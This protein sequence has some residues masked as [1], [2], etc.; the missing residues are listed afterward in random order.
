[1]TN[2][3]VLTSSDLSPDGVRTNN[4]R[5]DFCV[6]VVFPVA[7]LK[8]NVASCPTVPLIIVELSAKVI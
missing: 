6:E 3:R 2:F 1:M 5:R 4:L 8:L 7:I